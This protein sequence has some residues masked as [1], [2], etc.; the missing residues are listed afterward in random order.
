MYKLV[1]RLS[2]YYVN[3]R[4][5]PFTVHKAVK[6]AIAKS[7]RPSIIQPSVIHSIIPTLPNLRELFTVFFKNASSISEIF[8]S[9]QI[10]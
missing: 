6:D 9:Y 1:G 8:Y 2:L 3:W 5:T 4:F 7:A 10:T